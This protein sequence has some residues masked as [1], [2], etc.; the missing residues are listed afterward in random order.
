[1]ERKTAKI[2]KFNLETKDVEKAIRFK[3]QFIKINAESVFHPGALQFDAVL[4]AHYKRDSKKYGEHWAED[5]RRTVV[6][7]KNTFGNK[8]LR[9]IKKD[10]LNEFF[11]RNIFDLKFYADQ[12][13]LLEII[14]K[15]LKK[16]ELIGENIEKPLNFQHYR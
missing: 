12:R 10:E 4:D 16:Y 3:Q 7:L 1:M 6:H 14:Y 8:N 13:D 15:R 11:D 2:I 9:L 5:Y